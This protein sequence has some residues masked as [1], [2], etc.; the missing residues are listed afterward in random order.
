LLKKPSTFRNIILS[1]KCASVVLKSLAS[2]CIFQ[3]TIPWTTIRAG[4]CSVWWMLLA[5]SYSI[6]IVAALRWRQFFALCVVWTADV[7]YLLVI[8]LAMLVSS[9]TASVTVASVDWTRLLRSWVLGMLSMVLTR[10]EVVMTVDRHSPV[11]VYSDYISSI[12]KIHRL[13]IGHRRQ[14]TDVI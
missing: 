3:G 9:V 1:I 13:S 2:W 11:P 7:S 8:L 4:N 5:D 12:T 6:R 10:T 14:K